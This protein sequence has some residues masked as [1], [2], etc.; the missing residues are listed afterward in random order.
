MDWEKKAILMKL[1]QKTPKC[2][3][4]FCFEAMNVLLVCIFLIS[5]TRLFLNITFITNLEQFSILSPSSKI[6]KGSIDFLKKVNPVRLTILTI[7]FQ[8]FISI[9]ALE[10]V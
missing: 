5:R 8:S 1:L 2:V 9:D 4:K 6:L 7:L 10:L 3:L